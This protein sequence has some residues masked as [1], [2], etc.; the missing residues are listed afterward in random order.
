MK[1]RSKQDVKYLHKPFGMAEQALYTFCWN[2]VISFVLTTIADNNIFGAMSKEDDNCNNR[3]DNNSNGNRIN[4]T[5]ILT[6]Q[7]GYRHYSSTIYLFPTISQMILIHF[8]YSKCFFLLTA[9]AEGRLVV[10]VIMLSATDPTRC[11]AAHFLT[12]VV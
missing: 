6:I 3:G 2:A 5:Q 12:P 7:Q 8:S 10:L 11:V 9:V 4:D 1:T